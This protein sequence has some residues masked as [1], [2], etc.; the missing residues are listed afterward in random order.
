MVVSYDMMSS[1]VISCDVIPMVFCDV[2]MSFSDM[3]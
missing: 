1:D 3:S 2:I